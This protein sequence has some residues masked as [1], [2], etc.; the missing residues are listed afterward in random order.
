MTQLSA[1]E[2]VWHALTRVA[3]KIHQMLSSST[4]PA[5][6]IKFVGA[7]DTVKAVD[8]EFLHDLSFNGSIQH[9][10]HALALNENRRAFGAEYLY[11]NFNHPTTS[12]LVRTCLQA[13]FTGAHIDIGGS[14]AKDGL[15]LY[16]LQWMMIESRDQ[17]L[18]LKFDGS[19][20]GRA[21]LTDPL[22]L[23][24]LQ[25]ADQKLQIFTSENKVVTKMQDIRHLHNPSGPHGSKYQ[26]EVNLN[27]DA[28]W[29]RKDRQP[30][31][32][33]DELTGYCRF[34]KPPASYPPDC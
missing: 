12:L 17:G 15:S 2:P 9:M 27:K 23:V 21:P 3:L 8:D 29:L 11:P 33:D 26:V 1:E 13:W 34:G 14:A 10:R 25:D 32:N 24:S 28:F 18:C 20:G 7:F 16:P 4:K 31:D 30:F 6:T 22:Q 19:F 5:P